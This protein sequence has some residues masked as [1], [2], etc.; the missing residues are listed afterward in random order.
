MFSVK[1]HGATARATFADDAA[2]TAF[3]LISLLAQLITADG[4]II[5][6][7]LTVHDIILVVIR[8]SCSRTH[9]QT[10]DSA[11]SVFNIDVSLI[12]E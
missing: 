1:R 8:V 4:R 6:Y 11:L 12:P 7:R 9:Q 3:T 5:I 10:I 2:V